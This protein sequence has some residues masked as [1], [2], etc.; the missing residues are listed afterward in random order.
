MTVTVPL[1]ILWALALPIVIVCGVA[2][3]IGLWF[4]WKWITGELVTWQ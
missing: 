3:A 2:L 1:W 4:L